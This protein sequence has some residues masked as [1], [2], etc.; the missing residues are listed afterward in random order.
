MRQQSFPTGL[1]NDLISGSLKQAESQK[2]GKRAC[3]LLLAAQI[4][5]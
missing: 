4:I 5:Q 3:P 1:R 2:E